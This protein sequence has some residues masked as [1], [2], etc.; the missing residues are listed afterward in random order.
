MHDGYD[1]DEWFCIERVINST[2]TRYQSAEEVGLQMSSERR[3]EESCRSHA[4]SDHGLALS[5]GNAMGYVLLVLR[6]ISCFYSGPSGS[7]LLPQ[8]NRC[9]VVH[10]LTLP[11]RGIGSTPS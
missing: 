7:V 9:S 3:R 1:D 5:G 4:I 10:G 8:Q 2:Q 11:L 6:M